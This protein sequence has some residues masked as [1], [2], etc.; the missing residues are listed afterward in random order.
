MRKLCLV[1]LA[2]IA[3]MTTGALAQP[4][5]SAPPA[6]V[7]NPAAPGFEA[8]R[9]R[10]LDELYSRLKESP[11]PRSARAIEREIAVTQARSGSD[12][13]DLLMARAMMM[14]ERR[15]VDLALSILDAVIDLYPDYMEARARRAALMMTRNAFGQ[16]VV[17]LEQVLL[18]DPRNWSAATSL[19]MIFHQLGDNV[20][21]A[22]AFRKALELNPHVER[23]PEL[24]R[25]IAPEVE[26]RPI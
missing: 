9:A 20:R 12:T 4:S 8:D 1:S 6:F 24:M 2:A 14:V 21:A 15:E 11:N 25:R 3:L 26:G 19:G 13:G 23:V 5:G 22:A 18:R 7:G 10:R 16:A 17:D